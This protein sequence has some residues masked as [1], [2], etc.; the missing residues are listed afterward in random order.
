MLTLYVWTMLVQV[1]IGI[2]Y[3]YIFVDIIYV[4]R[5]QLLYIW[6]FSNLRLYLR[7][8]PPPPP[9]WT[10]LTELDLTKF[11]NTYIGYITCKVFFHTVFYINMYTESLI[12]DN[13]HKWYEKT[14]FIIVNKL[15]KPASTAFIEFKVEKW[16][17][18]S[19]ERENFN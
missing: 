4:Y 8:E 15:L 5:V 17:L 1:C 14:P 3:N 2:L 13:L 9:P 11:I 16:G 6:S 10:L 18:K 12:N 7:L 19:K